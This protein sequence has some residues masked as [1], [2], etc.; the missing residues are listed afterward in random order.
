MNQQCQ[1]SIRKSK[2]RWTIK[3]APLL[4]NLHINPRFST[5]TCN[6][7]EKESRLSTRSLSPDMKRNSKVLNPIIRKVFVMKAGAKLDQSLSGFFY[8][9]Q[10]FKDHVQEMIEFF[11]YCKNYFSSQVEFKYLIDESGRNYN[12]LHEIDDKT[13]VVIVSKNLRMSQNFCKSRK[14]G[15]LSERQN[16]KLPNDSITRSSSPHKSIKSKKSFE[17][18]Q[19]LKNIKLG[20]SNLLK[21]IEKHYPNIDKPRMRALQK[22]YKLSDIKI[23]KLNAKFKTLILLSCSTDPNHNLRLGISKKAFIEYNNSNIE[24]AYVLER[25]FNSFDHD[26]GGTISWHE[27]L[28]TASLIE[29][30]TNSQKVDMFFRVYDTNNDG[31]LSYKEIFDLCKVQLGDEHPP[32]MVEELANYSASLVFDIARLDYDQEI[33]ISMIKFIIDEKKDSSLAEIFCSF[34]F[35]RL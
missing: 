3:K 26:E 1:F 5:E 30:G 23:L 22:Q 24:K 2:T 33:P 18:F 4:T 27:F 15:C 8:Y 31:K 32:S 35:L 13:H 7:L 17:K 10:D 20:I 29:N 11:K 12:C 9:I 16:F 21:E 25:I 6:S 19:L 28:R 34:K 14:S